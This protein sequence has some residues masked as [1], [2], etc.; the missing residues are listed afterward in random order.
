MTYSIDVDDS[1]TLEPFPLEN[2]L[3]NHT[4]NQRLLG[5]MNTPTHLSERA[6]TVP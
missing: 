3:P 1:M 4:I 5:R 2:M 6:V